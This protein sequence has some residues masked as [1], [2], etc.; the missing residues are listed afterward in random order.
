MKKK[1]EDASAIDT[2][3]FVPFLAP[4]CP[5]SVMISIASEDTCSGLQGVLVG[6]SCNGQ[7]AGG[8]VVSQPSP[9]R[10]L[11]G[12]RRG[13]QLLLHGLEGTKVSVDGL[14]QRAGG[15]AGIL[16]GAEVLPEDGVVDVAATVELQGTVKADDCTSVI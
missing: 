6:A 8:L 10:T 3:S 12:H 15:L 16:F 2:A 5:A 9:A 7:F 13:G 11:D 4:K 1:R 14:H